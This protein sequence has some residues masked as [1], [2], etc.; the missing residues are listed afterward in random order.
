MKINLRK[1]AALQIAIEKQIEAA[2]MPL[3]VNIDRY[4][5]PE[6]VVQKAKETFNAGFLQK[7]ELL[8]V[9]YGIRERTA[10]AGH[11]AGVPTLLTKDV[12]IGKKIAWL[13]PFAKIRDFAKTTR[14]LGLAQQDLQND[15][16]VQYAHQRRDFFTVSIVGENDVKSRQREVANLKREKQAIS[17]LLLDANVKNEIDLTPYEEEILKKYGLI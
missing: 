13:E 10:A 12:H 15:P 17:D 8:D 2:E 14:E 5:T 6:D 1:S 11:R 7:L 16:P 3:T 4:V 9:L